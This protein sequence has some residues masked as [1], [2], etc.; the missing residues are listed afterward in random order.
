MANGDDQSNG[1]G[2]AGFLMGLLAGT[3]LGAGLCAIGIII[4]FYQMYENAHSSEL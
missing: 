4:A 3:V 1:G 2:G